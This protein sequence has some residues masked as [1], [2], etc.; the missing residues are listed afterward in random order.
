[1]L[2]IIIIIIMS[3]LTETE[4]EIVFIGTLPLLLY[5]IVFFITYMYKDL[6][7]VLIWLLPLLFPGIFLAVFLSNKV[8]LI[9][10]MR[11]YSVTVM[12]ILLSYAAN[13]LL[14][15]VYQLP[16]RKSRVDYYHKKYEQQLRQKY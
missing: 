16:E 8:E 3:M 15:L 12:N 14:L 6:S 10:S 4:F 11:G 5:L 2:I 7:N 13:I 1:M 9:S